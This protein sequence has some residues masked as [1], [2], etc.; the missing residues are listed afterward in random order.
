LIVA[1]SQ[2]AGEEELVAW[3]SRHC[4][5][6]GRSRDPLGRSLLHVAASC[7][8]TRL[9]TWLLQYKEAALNGKDTESGYSA[10]HRA[11]FYGQIRTVVFLINKGEYGTLIRD[12]F[13]F[14]SVLVLTSLSEEIR[15]VTLKKID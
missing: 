8:L 2:G 15:K 7:G 1:A 14:Y 11:V 10:L 5:G 6:P 12:L 4:Y 13:A 3:I 9:L